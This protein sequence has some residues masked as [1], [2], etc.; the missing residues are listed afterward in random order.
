[1]SGSTSRTCPHCGKKLARVSRDVFQRMFYRKLY[2]CPCGRTTLTDPRPFF[3]LVARCPQCGRA[4]LKR[5]HER[6][7]IDRIL[8]NPFRISQLLLG[9]KL[10]HCEFCRLQFHDLRPRQE[11]P[12]TKAMN[13]R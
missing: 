10:Y 4:D 12:E 2:A 8:Y 9:G 7:T 13:S 3:S 6:D 5:R 11:T 1:M